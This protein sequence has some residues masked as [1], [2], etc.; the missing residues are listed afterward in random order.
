[1]RAQAR[2]RAAS[3]PRSPTPSTP[4]ARF[5]EEAPGFTGKRVIT[6]KGEKGDANEAVIK[7][8]IEAGMLI[9]RGR[10]K[11]QYPHSWRSKKP[12][13]FRNTPQWFIA[14]DKDIADA[15]GTAKP[16]DTLRAR[17]LA[18]IEATRW[19]PP[20]G[21]NRITGMIESRPDWVISRQRAWGVPIAVFVREQG[22]GSVEI[23]QGRARQ[24]AHR[25]RLRARGRR[26]LVRGRR[27]RALPRR[28]VAN[29][30]W[31]KVD[32][33]LDVWFDSGS[34]HA[35]VLED[36]E[37]FPTLAGIRR[38]RDGG[39]DTVMYLEGSDQH[40]G[41]FHSSLLESCGTRGRAPF[42]VVLTHG[43]ILDEEGRKMSKSLGNVDRAAGRDQA[44][45]RRH[46]AAVGGAVRLCR[47]PAHRPGDPEDHG[48]D[49]PQAAQ[50]AAL[51]ARHARAFPTPR[52]ASRRREMP[53]LERL[54]LHRLAELD[55]LVRAGLRRLR[56]QAH[57]RRAQ[58]S[59]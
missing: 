59:S 30:D 23:L 20:Q 5:T 10:L 18:A 28:R 1:M 27:A 7:A 48:R 2:K 53:E 14:M 52:T 38:K 56:L 55:A 11:H 49:L 34:T 54:M 26:R 15:D 51:D 6:D 4:T 8:L 29:E 9:A 41:W 35:F 16:G 57:L 31:E 12:V 42:D 36:P 39:P 25:R 19:V 21:E 45:R 44:V 13:I 17:A 22:D 33:I 46:P 43:F 24:P 32:D 37:H 50:H 58:R 3:T 40:R 47:R